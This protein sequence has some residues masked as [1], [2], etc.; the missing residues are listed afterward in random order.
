M[1]TFVQRFSA[2]FEGAQLDIADEIFAPEFI[3][4]L[5]LASSLDRE[6][7]KAYIRIFYAALPRLVQE[8]NEVIISEDR[9]VLRLTYNGIHEGALFGIPPAGAPVSFEAIGIFRFDDAGR[10]VENWALIDV[11]GLFAQIGAFAAEK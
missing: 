5:P 1:M 3:G 11:I 8:V 10:A 6:R 9:L 4:H 2:I 7:W